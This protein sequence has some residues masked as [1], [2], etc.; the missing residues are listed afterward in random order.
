MYGSPDAKRIVGRTGMGVGRSLLC[1]TCIGA[2][3]A[4]TGSGWS[5]QELVRSV[6]SRKRFLFFLLLLPSFVP[7][8]LKRKES[9]PPVYAKTSGGRK[10]KKNLPSPG[11]PSPPFSNF[12]F[13]QE[14]LCTVL[15]LLIPKMASLIYLSKRESLLSSSFSMK[16][17]ALFLFFTKA[18]T[19]LKTN[20][21][22]ASFSFPLALC[23]NGPTKTKTKPP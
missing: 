11:D 22:T 4:G 8:F 20:P 13:N 23:R 6:W 5:R 1:Q 17:A 21:R 2:D 9:F 3:H 18:I 14:N 10:K 16:N 7:P 12:L 19:N 15:S